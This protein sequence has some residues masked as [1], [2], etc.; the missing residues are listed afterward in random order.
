MNRSASAVRAL[1]RVPTPVPKP[2][3][4]KPRQGPPQVLPAIEEPNTEFGLGKSYEHV[5]NE[6]IKLIENPTLAGGG[7]DI[8]FWELV[9]SSRG[10]KKEDTLTA[11]YGWD[12]RE[13]GYNATEKLFKQA[14]LDPATLD[15]FEKL[16]RD[17]LEKQREIEDLHVSQLLLFPQRLLRDACRG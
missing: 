8:P 15:H 17:S 13:N 4:L 9:P 12:L 11:G 7:T 2:Q 3:G 10:G 1:L 16:A 14:K 6:Q 5:R